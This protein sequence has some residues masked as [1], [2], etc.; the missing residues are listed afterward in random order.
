MEANRGDAYRPPGRA[1]SEQYGRAGSSSNVPRSAEQQPQ[2]IQRVRPEFTLGGSLREPATSGE[3]NVFRTIWNSLGKHW[4]AD[5]SN[6]I[7]YLEGS[8]EEQAQSALRQA[9]A[10]PDISAGIGREGL[11]SLAS[12]A[13]YDLSKAESLMQELRGLPA[14]QIIRRIKVG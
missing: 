8:V 1:Y 14:S 2:V 10:H 4:S 13:G 12:R 6:P 11:E 5:P 9:L 3:W 7:H